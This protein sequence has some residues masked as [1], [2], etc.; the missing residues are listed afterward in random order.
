MDLPR[1]AANCPA[2][3]ELE[4]GKNYAYCTCGLSEKQPFCDGAHKG[5]DYRPTLFTVPECKTAF[6]C[7]CKRTANGPYCDGAHKQLPPQ[8][9]DAAQ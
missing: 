4:P 7:Q 5:T 1:V 9:T 3:L 6:L 2:K 8:T